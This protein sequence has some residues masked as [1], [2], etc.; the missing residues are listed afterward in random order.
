MKRK[1]PFTNLDNIKLSTPFKK[2][3][4][5]QKEKRAKKKDLSFRVEQSPEKTTEFLKLN[6]S[7]STVTW[8]GH[9]TFLIQICGINILTDPV[10]ARRM[11]FVTRMAAPGI[12]VEELPEIQVVLI[13]HNHYDHLH[14][15]SLK[16]LKGEPQFLV[17]DG[18]GPDFKRRGLAKVE[19]FQWWNEK[20]IGNVI[21]TFVPA[22]HWSKRTLWDTN[23]SLWGGWVIKSMTEDCSKTIY[24]AG[25]S[26]YFRGFR[27]IGN[28][29]K[30][31]NIALLPIGCYDPEWFMCVQHVTPEEAVAAFRDTGAE[32]FVPMHYEAFRLGDDTPEEAIIRLEL[33]WNQQDLDLSRLK[34]LKLGETLF[35]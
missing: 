28:R 20:L 32:Y 18:L 33:E 4:R 22:Q 17:P 6:Q 35:I 19:E 10:W 3:L 5:W 2:F 12:P 14:F 21:F 27:E 15:K 8:V 23:L 7:K 11:G 16:Q 29:F 31:I 26:G 1:K 9:A 13:S 24:F 25:D 30:N 34:M